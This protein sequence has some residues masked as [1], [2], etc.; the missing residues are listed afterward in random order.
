MVV[1]V[2]IGNSKKK[3]VNGF[4][5]RICYCHQLFSSL[6]KNSGI[7]KPPKPK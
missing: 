1:A 5:F 7:M 3:N 4:L 6:C 2:E